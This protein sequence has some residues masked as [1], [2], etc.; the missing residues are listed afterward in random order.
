MN[1]LVIYVHGKDGSAQEA[2]RY[3][4]L[5]PGQDVVGFDYRSRT[6]WEARE[7]FPAFAD[8]LLRQYDS[9]LLIANSIG[10][11]LS[12]HAL[13]DRRIDRSFLISPIV[14]MEALI[15][16]M[17]GWVGVTEDVLRKRRE[18]PTAFGETLSWNYLCYVRSHPLSWRIPT[19][20]LYGEKDTMTDRA[21][22][23][24]F[25]ER[26]GAGLT[27]MLG[28]EHWFHT[29]EQM[30]FLDSWLQEKTKAPKGGAHHGL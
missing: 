30:A 12:M 18:I 10:A 23:T 25:A 3:R 27:V 9:V 2:A 8:P 21:A 26:I 19:E 7:E 20:I 28:G 29:E 17:M 6:P 24:A 16:S 22:I 14:D 11:F 15:R 13:A 5:F 1:Q 4:P